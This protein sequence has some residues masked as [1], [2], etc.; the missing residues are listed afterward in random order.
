MQRHSFANKG[1]SSHSYGF[2]SSQ[3]WMWELD[4]KESWAPQNWCF[5]LCCWRLL[6]VP[7]T[8]RRTKQSILKEISPEC[9]LEGLMQ[10][11]KHQ[12]SVNICNV[13]SWLIWKD[14]DVG[15]DWR[16]DE[17][18]TTEDEMVWWHHRLHG[19]SFFFFFFFPLKKALYFPFKQLGHSTLF[20]MNC[21]HFL[22][23]HLNLRW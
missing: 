3:K 18:G 9:F 8:A 7:W 15:K 13:K 2:S 12:Y 1:P 17:K 6:R 4:Y 20:H 21:S 19:H 11:L 23:F 14:P 22:N 10:K 16:R 5:E